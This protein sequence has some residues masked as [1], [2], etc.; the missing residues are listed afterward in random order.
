MKRLSLIFAL[1]VVGACA[2]QLVPG[3]M[4]SQVV[5]AQCTET[6]AGKNISSSGTLV[7]DCTI[8]TGTNCGCT[9]PKKCPPGALEEVYDY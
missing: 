8:T 2:A 1:L 5:Y 9:V 3:L 6:V 4:Q 7:C